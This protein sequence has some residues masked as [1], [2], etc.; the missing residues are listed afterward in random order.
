MK[1]KLNTIFW[2]LVLIGIILLSI[3]VISI[4]VEYWN[5]PVSQCPLWVVWLLK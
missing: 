1:D 5:V 2:L 4:K 3:V